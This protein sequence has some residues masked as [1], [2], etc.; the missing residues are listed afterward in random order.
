M[1]GMLLFERR[2]DIAFEVRRIMRYEVRQFAMLR[3]TPSRLDRVQFGR[4]GG[5]P[6]DSDVFEA[7][8][9]EPFGSRAMHGPAI[10]TDDQGLP[11]LTAKLFHEGNDLVGANVALVNLKRRADM[12][13]GGRERDRSNHAQSVVPVPG[14]LHGRFAA[15]SPGAAI[16]GLKLKPGFIDKNNTG[17]ASTGFFLIRDQSS[18]RHRSTASG[19]CSR[20]TRRG[21][22]GEKPRSC[23]TRPMWA[24]WYETP[25]C[26]RTTLETRAQVH[27]SVRY[28]AATGPWRRSLVNAP[29]CFSESLGSG[30][31]CGLAAKPST[32]SAFHVR[33]QR[34]TLVRLTPKSEAISRRGFRSW[35]CSAARRRRASS[36][37]ALPGGLMKHNTLLAAARVL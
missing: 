5:Q 15:R 22:W 2:T 17:A 37:A 26:L 27:K 33:F 7:R 31:G 25:N 21:F 14:P 6:L 32:P 8:G 4:V 35:K 30:P 13:P 34:F 18:C 3:V 20:A 10:P 29:L 24:G 16:H 12:T 36:S 11:P 1:V 28:P 23:S 9:G 19:S